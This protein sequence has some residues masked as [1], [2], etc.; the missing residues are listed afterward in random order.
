M[1]N[2]LRLLLAVAILFSASC[3]G[4]FDEMND[5][6]NA[7]TQV[8][9]SLIVTQMLNF[10]KPGLQYGDL[11]KEHLLAK[12]MSWV[13][14]MQDVQYNRLGER[15]FGIYPDLANIEKMIGTTT[16]ASYDTYMGFGL[17]IKTFHLFYLSALVGDIPY[18]EALQ[19]E[20]GLL[21]PKYDT[22]KEVMKQII[23]DLDAAYD[24]FN[25]ATLSISGDITDLNGSIDKWKRIANLLELRV[26][27][28]LSKKESDTDLN[29]KA[30]FAEVAARPLLESNDDNLKLTFK[31]ASGMFSS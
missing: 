22:Q 29:I 24:H 19:G 31:N 11:G 1:K 6:P 15:D 4:N 9:T 16:E 30:K 27:I 25:K 20:Q 8:P 14:N 12:Y 17:F 2:Y 28:N 10:M 7:T 13:E 5:N 18:S 21:K 26:L 3:T 23:A